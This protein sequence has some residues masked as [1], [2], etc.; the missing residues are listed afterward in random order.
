MYKTRR[1]IIT[2]GLNSL[3]GVVCDS[4]EGAFY[5]FPNISGTEGHIRLSFANSTELIER[6]ISK[7][8]KVILKN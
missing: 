5:S 4:P 8:T 6:A 1:D 2:E 7:N 3:P